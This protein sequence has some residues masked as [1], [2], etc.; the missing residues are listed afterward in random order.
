MISNRI[1]LYMV[2]ACFLV[3]LTGGS[4]LF[5]PALAGIGYS[6]ISKGVGFATLFSVMLLLRNG[7]LLSSRY[8]KIIQGAIAILLAGALMKILH[9]ASANMVI[10]I[11]CAA[12]IIVYTAWFFSKKKK[13]LLDILKVLW[14]LVFLTGV[15]FRINHWLYADVLYYTAD[16]LLLLTLVS[17]GWTEFRGDEKAKQELRN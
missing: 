16:I 17:F 1:S 11:A 13:T 7:T 4:M 9:I 15:D 10:M 12:V 2:A 14:V 6:L 8:F 3:A 5:N